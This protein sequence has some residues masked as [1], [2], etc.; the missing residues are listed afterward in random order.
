MTARSTPAAL[1]TEIRRR[2]GPRPDLR[3]PPLVSLVVLNRDGVEHL[4]R[5]LAGLVEHTDYPQLELILVDN[6]SSDASLEFIRAVEAPFPIS[7]VANPHNESFSDG[8][9]QGAELA[10]G[11]LLLFLNNDIEPFEPGW[12]AELVACLRA[13]GAGAV[14]ATLLTPDESGETAS[15][16]LLQTRRVGLRK[17]ES[18]ALV[19]ASND[20][21][22]ELLDKGFGEDV[23]TAIGYGACILIERE[24]FRRVDGF[25]HGYFYS[26]ED[27][28][29][30]LKVRAAGKRFLYSGRSVLIHLG[31]ASVDRLIAD[32]DGSLRRRN[33]RLFEELWG[34]RLWREYELDRLAGGEL[35]TVSEQ[36]AQAGGPAR[37]EVLAPG[38]CLLADRAGEEEDAALALLEGGLA[39]RLRHLTLRDEAIEDRRALY[40]DVAVYLRGPA[41]Y[42]P[43]PGQLN[44]L[45]A[46]SGLEALHGIE[47]SRYDL[48]VTANAAVAERL[49]RDS[50]ET[51][52][53]TLGER[54]AEKLVEAAL[55][56]M[57]EVGMRMRVEA[58]SS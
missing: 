34:P 47:C 49:R 20:H 56:R 11:E 57:R 51:P 2:L 43:K 23:E 52:V 3:D 39:R 29:L 1:A 53:V 55:A 22:R 25:T 31:S 33:R 36:E 9:N 14:G 16:Y 24:L 38:F 50:G 30:L 46:V 12:L 41:R 32:G 15:G 19:P 4:R 28:D 6:G 27:V 45:W 44:V 13:K 40:H 48:A 58:T 17:T 7:I 8:C 37:E 21:R 54:P 26:G 5:L 10:S 42:V 35:W 18:G